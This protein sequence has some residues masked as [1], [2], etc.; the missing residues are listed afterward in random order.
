MYP[1]RRHE[2]AGPRTTRKA[3][4]A[5]GILTVTRTLTR[6]DVRWMVA[7]NARGLATGRRVPAAVSGS[8]LRRGAG[9]GATYHRE[10]REVARGAG[11]GA[12]STVTVISAGSGGA[13]ASRA[14]GAV[15]AGASRTGGGVGT[16]GVGVD[17]A[18]TV[19]AGSVGVVTVGGGGS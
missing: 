7:S 11:G 17:G 10:R 12:S 18:G 2:G 5:F 19:G 6:C 9:V 16:V 3:R 15:T 14:E 4:R 13:G 1:A 8:K